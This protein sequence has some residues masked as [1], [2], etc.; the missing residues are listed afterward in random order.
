MRQRKVAM[1]R[2][3]RFR[4]LLHHF[5]LCPHLFQRLRAVLKLRGVCLWDDPPLIGL[6]NKVLVALLIGKADR[7]LS[8]LEIE[9]RALHGVRRRLPAHQRVLPPVAFA[10]HIPV[11]APMVSVPVAGLRCGFRGLVDSIEDIRR[12][13]VTKLGEGLDIPHGTCL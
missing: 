13:R 5:L 1:G 9:M 12:D 11:H 2:K 8:R 10:E 7:V 4:V 6:L 3:Y